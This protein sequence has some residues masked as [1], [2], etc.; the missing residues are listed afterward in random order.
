MTLEISL[1]I[2]YCIRVKWDS[3]NDHHLS[4]IVSHLLIPLLLLL[5]NG[6]KANSHFA[7]FPRPAPPPL[8]QNICKQT[9]SL[10]SDSITGIHKCS[11]DEEIS[12]R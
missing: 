12:K 3:L 5:L 9:E 8:L 1:Y 2:R 4:Y 11:A 7:H 10:N 6:Q